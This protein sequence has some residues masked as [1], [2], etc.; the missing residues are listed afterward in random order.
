[1]GKSASNIANF[2]SLG[3]IPC[4]AYLDRCRQNGTTYHQHVCARRPAVHVSFNTAIS[5]I[6][7]PLSSR[8]MVGHYRITSYR[9]T[10]HYINLQSVASRCHSL[11]QCCDELCREDCA[12]ELTEG[13]SRRTDET[14]WHISQLS[15]SH[16]LVL[17]L[18]CAAVCPLW[19]HVTFTQ[20]PWVSSSPA[21]ATW[22]SHHHSSVSYNQSINQSINQS[23]VTSNTTHT[24]RTLHSL[25]DDNI[26]HRARPDRPATSRTE[27]SWR[28][29]NSAHPTQSSSVTD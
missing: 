11:I 2:H 26:L 23:A 18:H 27:L 13:N 28:H 6:Y 24:Q 7:S 4:K 29:L 20:S 25:S 12:C 3:C 1:M 21:A 15:L 5:W 14:L 16:Q 9:S 10:Q 22:H 8:H 19:L 17:H